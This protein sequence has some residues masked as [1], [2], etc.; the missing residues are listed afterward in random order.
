M[1][2]A[3]QRFVIAHEKGVLPCGFGKI[4]SQSMYVHVLV[5]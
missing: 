3:I 5:Y 1:Y 4:S 2:R